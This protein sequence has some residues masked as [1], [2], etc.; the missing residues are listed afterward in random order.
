[1]GEPT[2]LQKM[3]FIDKKESIEKFK[4]VRNLSKV[5][6]IL[7][8]SIGKKKNLIDTVLTNFIKIDWIIFAIRTSQFGLLECQENTTETVF[9]TKVPLVNKKRK[10]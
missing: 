6:V 2:V 10:Q 3:Y 8:S 9:A 5:N 7:L 4:C 1:M